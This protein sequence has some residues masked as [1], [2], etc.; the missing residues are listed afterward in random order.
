[1]PVDVDQPNSSLPW[2]S[3]LSPSSAQTPWV[4]NMTLKENILFGLP[5]DEDRYKQVIHACALELDL[6]V[7]RDTAWFPGGTP[8]MRGVC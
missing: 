2:S 6:Q 7:R 4:Q 8:V 5:F 1:M 3:V